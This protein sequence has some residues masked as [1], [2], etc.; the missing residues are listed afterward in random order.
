V[1][2]FGYNE[3]FVV[4]GHT[5]VVFTKK[6]WKYNGYL[7]YLRIIRVF[8]CMLKSVILLCA[9]SKAIWKRWD[10]VDLFGS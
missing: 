2:L 9:S 10:W 3:V 1:A 6:S 8:A 7:E 4:F 5:D